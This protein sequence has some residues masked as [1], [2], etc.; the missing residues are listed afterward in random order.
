LQACQGV[1]RISNVMVVS[2]RLGLFV[3]AGG[4]IISFGNNR[5]AGNG[6]DGAPTLTP[7]QK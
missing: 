6:T 7:G 1:I 4:S 3:S 5:I 2:N